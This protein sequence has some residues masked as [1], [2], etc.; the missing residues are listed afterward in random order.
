MLLNPSKY[1][2]AILNAK[3]VWFFLNQTTTKLQGN[4][5]QMQLPYV[6]QIP[7]PKLKEKDQQPFIA[8]VDRILELKKEGKD[9]QDLENEIDALVYRLYELTDEEIAIVEGKK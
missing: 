8:L 5:Q 3:A 7:I 9:T 1:L 2:L 4:A 6:T